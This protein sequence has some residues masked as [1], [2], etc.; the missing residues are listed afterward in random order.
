[1]TTSCATLPAVPVSDLPADVQRLLE[2]RLPGVA[3]MLRWHAR[4][5]T[6][7]DTGRWLARA[8]LH[9]A[10]CGD[11][12]ALAA[13]GPRPYVFIAPVA[14]LSRAVYNH[15]TGE[16]SLPQPAGGPAVPPV[17][18]DPLLASS[19]LSLA[20]AP[21]TPIPPSGIFSHA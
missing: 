4:S 6:K 17:R 1:M 21:T 14:V 20:P 15:V 16:L 7:L 9:A 19:L 8:P 13:A 11:R 18:L 12:F 2:S 5:G 3:G 10:V